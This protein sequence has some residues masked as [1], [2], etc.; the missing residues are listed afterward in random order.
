VG[1]FAPELLGQ[2]LFYIKNPLAD[3]MG[4]TRGEVRD[5][6]ERAGARSLSASSGGIPAVRWF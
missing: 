2:A 6:G 5:Q 4:D 3:V 1:E